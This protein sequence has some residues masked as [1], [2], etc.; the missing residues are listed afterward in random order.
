MV[1][2]VVTPAQG[3]SVDF[4][5]A[6]LETWET[7]KTS[8]YAALTPEQRCLFNVNRFDYQMQN[9]GLHGFLLNT[10]CSHLAETLADLR[11][12]GA[13]SVRLLDLV[14][15][16]LGGAVPQNAARYFELLAQVI[17]RGGLEGLVYEEHGLL[18]KL[19]A[20]LGLEEDRA[21]GA[22]V[23]PGDGPAARKGRS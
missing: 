1:S 9:G 5:S 2:I 6:L 16:E 4:L 15:R 12:V 20:H 10:P 21:S 13:D 18:K 11:R 23:G 17:E 3:D 7:E 14:V 8:G 19:A 22:A